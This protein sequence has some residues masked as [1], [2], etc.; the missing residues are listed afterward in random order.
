MRILVVGCGKSDFNYQKIEGFY[1]A[2]SKIGETEWVQSIFGGHHN[3]YDIVFGEVSFSEIMGNV[4]RYQSMKIGLQFTWMSF[5]IENTIKLANL[6]PETLFINAYKSNFLNSE[7]VVK[8][9]SKH[10]SSYQF[11]KD[12]GVILD[13]FLNIDE[14]VLPPNLR[15]SYLPCS[16]STK[17]DFIEDK[18]YDIC[19]FGSLKNRPGVEECLNHLSKKYKVL[20][21]AYDK[22]HM[23]DPNECYNLYKKC[24]ITLSEQV[25]PVRIEFPVRLGESTSTGCRLFLI[26]D[27]EIVEDNFFVPDYTSAKTPGELVNKIESY[28]DNFDIKDSIKLYEDFK[29]TYDNAVSLILESYND[30]LI[31]INSENKNIIKNGNS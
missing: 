7:T 14:K 23:K 25:H 28:L 8:H 11:W 26:D 15:L 31:E 6:K 30:S 19:Y 3:E 16:L 9:I 12:E 4:A 1:K 2:F 22:G 21:N 18:E 20:T 13:D 10:G 17:E 27:L 5:N 24:K 29:S